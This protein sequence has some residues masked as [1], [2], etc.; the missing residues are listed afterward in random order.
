MHYAVRS[1]AM[2]ARSLRGVKALT[3]NVNE[4]EKSVALGLRGF[5]SLPLH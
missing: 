3:E 2:A 4:I 1:P 5:K